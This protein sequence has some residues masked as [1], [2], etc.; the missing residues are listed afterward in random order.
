MIVQRIER[1]QEV[2][3][4]NS[5]QNESGTCWEVL[6]LIAHSE[7]LMKCLI[8]LL[9]DLQFKCGVMALLLSLRTCC[10]R[11]VCDEMFD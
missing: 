7:C 11:Q 6:L 9:I 10:D 5:I 8:W 1:I 3:S 4:F 2:F